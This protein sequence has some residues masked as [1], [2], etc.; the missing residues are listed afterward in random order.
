[1]FTFSD[2][3]FISVTEAVSTARWVALTN[4]SETVGVTYNSVDNVFSEALFVYVGLTNLF[5]LIA[6]FIGFTVY[7]GNQGL[8]SI[9]HIL[10]NTDSHNVAF[11]YLTDLEEEVGSVDDAMMYFLSFAVILI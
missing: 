9:S 4:Y 10:N 8:K 5:Y 2:N 7:L 11:A 6:V 3:F 1:M